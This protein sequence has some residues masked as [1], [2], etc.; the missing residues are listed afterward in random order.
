VLCWDDSKKR[1]VH[2]GATREKEREKGKI[3]QPESFLSWNARCG[4]ESALPLRT[5]EE[6]GRKGERSLRSALPTMLA[7]ST[8]SG[9]GP[10]GGV[11][12]KRE[13]RGE[14]EKRVILA[15]CSILGRP[16]PPPKD[17]GKKGEREG[18][19]EKKKGRRG[20]VE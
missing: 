2:L 14:G 7:L 17:R 13:K 5:E 10:H 4:G 9:N 1:N 20:G 8:F 18:K 16:P 3:W 11:E 6:K 12:G 15:C 19:R